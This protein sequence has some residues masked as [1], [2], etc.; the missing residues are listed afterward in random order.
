MAYVIKFIGLSIQATRD[1]IPLTDGYQ[2]RAWL[3][4][5]DEVSFDSVTAAHDWIAG[6]HLGPDLAQVEELFRIEA[7]VA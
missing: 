5:Y 6:N 1:M 3:P 4:G 7:E 2:A